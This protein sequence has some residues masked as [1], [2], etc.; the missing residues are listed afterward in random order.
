MSGG[1]GD[2]KADADWQKAVEEAIRAADAVILLLGSSVAPTKY[3]ELEW[4]VALESY[5]ANRNKLLIPVLLGDAVLPSFAASFQALRMPEACWDWSP[6]M[7]AL[8]HGRG[9]LP[10]STPKKDSSRLTERLKN[11]EAFAQSIKKSDES[12]W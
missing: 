4:S 2:F 11:V 12:V 9:V 1:I 3:Q 10:D 8:L 7:E 6:V 5:W